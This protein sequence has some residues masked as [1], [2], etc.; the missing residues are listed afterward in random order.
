MLASSLFVLSA[1]TITGVYVREINKSNDD[2][3]VVDFSQLENQADSQAQNIASAELENTQSDLVQ[4]LQAIDDMDYDPAYREAHSTGVTNATTEETDNAVLES[5]TDDTQ[6]KEENA[7]ETEET[8][9]EAVETSAHIS[10]REFSFEESDT[11]QWPVAGNVLLNYSMDKTI[12][13][14]T[15]QQYKYNPA[16]VIAATEG[17]MICAA[18]D[19]EVVAVY[20]DAE[21]GQAVDINIGDGYQLTYG[22]LRDIPLMAGDVVEAGDIVGFVNAPSKYYSIEGSNIYFKLTKDGTPVNPL[23]KLE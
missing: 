6:N 4:D 3:Y 15:L 14:A 12:Y 2:G 16:I 7:T 13:F 8:E 18:T 22:Q 9:E 17:A 10:S 19:G 23:G 1:L 11:L 21:I 20:E 5:E